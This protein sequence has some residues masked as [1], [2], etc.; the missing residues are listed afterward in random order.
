MVLKILK[1]IFPEWIINLKNKLYQLN[2]NYKKLPSYTK[3]QTLMLNY[4]VKDLVNID[5]LSFK[6]KINQFLNTYDYNMEDFDDPE[7]QRVLS[8]K[9]GWGHNHDFGDFSL[10]GKL[11]DRHIYIPAVFADL[12]KILPPSLD[13]L[14]ILEIGTWTGGMSL[15]LCAMGA[16]VVAIEEVKKYYESLK[17]LKNAFNINN[18]E[19][20]HLSLYDCTTSE[21]QDSFDIVLFTGVLYHV[22]DPIL[23]LR[24]IF[25][26]LKDNGIILLET[27]VTTSKDYILRYRNPIK[28]KNGKKQLLGRTGWNWFVPSPKALYQMMRDVGFTKIRVSGIIKGRCFAIG[29]RMTHVDFIRSG[30]SAKV[31]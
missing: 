25:N 22:S 17:Y 19:P 30:I 5:P 14:R 7:R 13:G 12:F 9:F 15:L 20:L 28:V 4:Q 29:K 1:Y 24:I 10:K 21:F 6:K 3:F 2:F 31:R 26:S 18:L 11:G 27:A 16:H 23:A 8:V